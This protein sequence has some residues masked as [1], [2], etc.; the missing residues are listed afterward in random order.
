M[1]TY[2]HYLTLMY[3]RGI[4]AY[5][6]RNDFIIDLN[7]E[8]FDLQQEIVASKFSQKEDLVLYNVGTLCACFQVFFDF[9]LGPNQESFGK[10]QHLKD[11]SKVTIDHLVYKGDNDPNLQDN[12]LFTSS[13]KRLRLVFIGFSKEVSLIENQVFESRIVLR[14][15][16]LQV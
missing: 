15:S 6:L 10:L 9:L 4:R 5:H 1:T 8:E 3:L 14:Q 13:V 11:A 7:S 16:E 12:I 2:V